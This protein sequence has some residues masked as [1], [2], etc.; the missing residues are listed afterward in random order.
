MGSVQLCAE[1]AE[2][3]PWMVAMILPLCLLLYSPAAPCGL[4]QGAQGT[5]KWHKDNDY[6]SQCELNGWTTVGILC[7]E[8]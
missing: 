8:V 5:C 4:C 6:Y 7:E 3:G 1:A 2:T